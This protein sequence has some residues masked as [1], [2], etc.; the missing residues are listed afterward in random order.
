M[1]LNKST[2]N[3][4][5]F[6][7]HTWNPLGGQCPHGCSYCSTNKLMRRY[8]VM[9]DKY[10]GKPRLYLNALHTLGSGNFIFVCAQSDLFAE[11][12]PDEIVKRVLDHCAQNSG[13][14]Y[15]F[16]TKNPHRIADFIGDFVWIKSVICTT[17]ETNRWYD[18]IMKNSPCPSDRANNMMWL[19]EKFDTYATVEPIM[20]FDLDPMLE[21]IKMCNPEQVNIGA[22]SGNNGLPEPSA[23]KV[24]ALIVELETFTKVKQ[25]SNLGRLLK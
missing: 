23:E 3:M 22:D 11:T 10:T 21:L 25:K 4:Y 2:G 18:R 24:K 15:L 12:V 14:R 5:D 1:S 20:D 9:R 13:N 19:S 16:Q 6:V 8:P 7:T 17:I